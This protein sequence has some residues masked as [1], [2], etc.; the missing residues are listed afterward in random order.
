MG[1]LDIWNENNTELLA[2]SLGILIGAKLTVGGKV[3]SLD[4]E[5]TDRNLDGV[6]VPADC[7]LDSKFLRKPI[8]CLE[9]IVSV[10]DVAC[11]ASFTLAQVNGK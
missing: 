8:S 2:A 9:L 1:S 10:L 11:I 6:L 5:A 3:T 7:C 4:T